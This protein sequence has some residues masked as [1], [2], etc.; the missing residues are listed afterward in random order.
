M[1]RIVLVLLVVVL[2]F[3]TC[4]TALAEVESKGDASVRTPIPDNL[5][6]KMSL[7][8]DKCEEG[9]AARMDLSEL[10]QAV[11][12]KNREVREGVRSR[13]AEELGTFN[14]LR[15]QIKGEKEQH[16]Q[17]LGG[18]SQQ[19]REAIGNK[20]REKAVE[21]KESIMQS[22]QA[23][24][25]KMVEYKAKL[26][27]SRASMQ[28]LRMEMQGLLEELA[29]FKEE[30]ASIREEMKSSCEIIQGYRQ[31]LRE[32]I[33]A[34]DFDGAEAIMDNMISAITAQTEILK[35]LV[36]ELN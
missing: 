27:E 11:T 26:E 23:F 7:L 28:A 35:G 36:D 14:E 20:D 13:R 24:R 8:K 21:I 32:A 33:R 4:L 31:E 12:E 2:M 3:T 34:E 29:P 19:I 6:T 10:R 15:E 9:R 22:R 17:M 16:R 18:L 5:I 30:L 1:K 25:E